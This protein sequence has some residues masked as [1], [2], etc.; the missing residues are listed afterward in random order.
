MTRFHTLSL[1]FAFTTM[2]ISGCGDTAQDLQE[3]ARSA[4]ESGDHATAAST[5]TDALKLASGD[6]ALTWQLEQL[7]LEALARGGQGEQAAANLERLAN[8]FSAQVKVPLYL[9]TASYLKDAGDTSHA[10]DILTAGDARFP[11][12]HDQFTAAIQEMNKTQEL[13]PAE[14][15]KLKSLG[16]L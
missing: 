12:A 2:L 10:I 1:V 3:S 9:A 13:D 6:R 4:L 11:A 8:D 15:E 14:I 5:A 7:R 16:Y